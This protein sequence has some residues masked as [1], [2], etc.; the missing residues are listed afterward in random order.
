MTGKVIAMWAGTAML[1]L[2]GISGLWAMFGS[3]TV[4][5]TEA[6]V[7][8]RIN[9]Q[10]DKN[11]DVKGPA[12]F[13]VK[14]V[15]LTDATVHLVG[16]RVTALVDVEGVL[17]A[18]KEFSMTARVVGVPKYEG[19]AFFFT[20]ENV[21]VQTF[22]YE[23]TKPVEYWKRLADRYISDEKKERLVA[24]LAPAAEAWMTGI[25]QKAAVH[26]L[27]KHPIYRLKSDVKGVLI[28]A[29][30]ESVKIDQDRVVV[31]FSL[32]QLTIS[33]FLSILSLLVAIGMTWAL[34]ENPALL[35]LVALTPM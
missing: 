19:D 26:A 12:H 35:G 23:G 31:T 20:A 17:L 34:I 7:Q 1:F 27:E 14:T 13:V 3:H 11:I 5:F 8:E 25:A 6:Q 22:A 21:E 24:D 9:A 18:G 30:L 32:W 28:K 33:V 29:S 2:L 4:S 10:L 16:G 15:K